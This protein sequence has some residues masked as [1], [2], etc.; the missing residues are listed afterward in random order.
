MLKPFKHPKLDE[1]N[2]RIL[3]LL[4]GFLSTLWFIIRVV[5]KPSRAQ[6]PC[7]RAAAPWASAFVIYILS[8]GSSVF[9]LRKAREHFFNQRYSCA[10]LFVV[11][12]I[13]ASFSVM[14][15]NGAELWASK[16]QINA[17]G[18]Q[19]FESINTPVGQEVGIFP[20]RVVWAHNPDATNENCDPNEFGNTWYHNQNNNQE[21]IDSMLTKSLRILTG[22]GSNIESWDRIFSFHNNTRNK[23]KVN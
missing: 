10:T 17:G 6:Y 19:L 20:G 16:K 9:G 1:R 22:A 4:A 5:P 7:M 23:G 2:W 13:I 11:M 3:I 8:L 21:V 15:F 12:A 18:K 14:F